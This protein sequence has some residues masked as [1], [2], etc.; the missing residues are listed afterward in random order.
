LSLGKTWKENLETIRSRRFSRY[1]LC[2]QDFGSTIGYVHI[3]DLFL[4]GQ[5]PPNLEAINRHLVEVNAAEPLQNLLQQFADKG[6]HIAL[7]RDELKKPVGIVTLEDILEEIVGEV[8]DEFDFPKTWALIDALIP[9]A[10]EVGMDGEDRRSLIRRLLARLKAAN[11]EID[12]EE[13][14]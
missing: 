4:T 5:E 1:P 12:V 14:F 8:H 6:V 2:R 13:T 7:V 10:V 3:K 11:P 9:S